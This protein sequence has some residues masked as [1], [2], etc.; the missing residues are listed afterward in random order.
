MQNL[1]EIPQCLRRWRR[2]IFNGHAFVIQGVRALSCACFQKECIF[3]G[4]LGFGG[5]RLYVCA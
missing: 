4:T 3:Y 1:I 5:L 2:K